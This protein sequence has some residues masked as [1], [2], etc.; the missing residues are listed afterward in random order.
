M[1]MTKREFLAKQQ[2]R[3]VLSK[4][5]YPTYSY[6]IQDFDIHLTKDP[7]VI[8]YMIPSKGVI[9]LNEGLDLEQVSVVVR[10]EILHEF[11]N[12]A[13]RMQT[14][15][16][17]EAYKKEM[18]RA[19]NL[20][21]IAADYEISNRGYTERDKRNIRAI[22]LN[23]KTL[24]GLVTED[25]H[26]DWVGLSVEEMYDRLEQQ[27]KKDTEEAKKSLQDKYKDHDTNYIK[28]YNDIITKF[29]GASDDE[30]NKI[31]STIKTP[32]DVKA[33]LGGNK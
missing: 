7:G 10:H 14:K 12:H 9:T 33:L 26:P 1:S 3:E 22:H 5:G 32:E 17:D 19:N 24:S 18:S 15:L 20:I 31:L 29:Q 16:G 21:N 23:N 27:R 30:I 28:I 4:E 8:G 11:L 13:K 25:D 2:I 6:L